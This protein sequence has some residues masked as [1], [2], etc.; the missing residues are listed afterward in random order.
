V[1][2]DRYEF[3]RAMLRMFTEN[4]RMQEAH[5]SLLRSELSSMRSNWV[6]VYSGLIAE[7]KIT[8]IE[9]LERPDKIELINYAKE[10]APALDGEKFKD[11]CRSL[12]TIEYF[13]N[14]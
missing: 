5:F 6:Y 2:P 8:K 12:V 7:K 11:L 3:G 4:G 9:D 10:I 13:L 14:Q 1:I